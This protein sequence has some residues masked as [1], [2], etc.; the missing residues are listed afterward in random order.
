MPRAVTADQF[1]P[2]E[3]YRLAEH[4]PGAPGEG[5]VRVAIKAAGVSFVDVLTARGEYQ[6]KPPLPYV[7][8]SEYAGVV[9]AVGAGV[10]ALAVGDRV[11]GSSLGNTFAEAGLF[12][13]ANVSK[14][15]EGMDFAEAAVFPVNYQT[16]WHALVDRAAARPG[17]S[18]LV[19]G[20]AGGTGFA[21]VEVGKYLGLHVI[22]SASSPEKQAAARAGGADAVVQTGAEDWREQVKAANGGK[23]IDIVFDPVG[24]DATDLAFRTL[25][26]GGR[27]L[28]IGFT[29]GLTA[30]KTNLPLLKCASL[31]GVQMR[32]HALARP[33]EAAANRVKVMELAGE[34]HFH[35]A[36][37]ARFPLED[38]VAAMELAFSGKAAGRVVLEMA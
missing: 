13:A 35:P 8:G 19:L 2:P 25:G 5:Q 33:E 29:G 1:G 12:N 26:Y 14:V 36:I 34:G 24:G 31:V 38:Y 27:H 22:A 23:D 9:E 30:L 6:F 10:S 28:V 11:F 21:A 15:P 18:L 16:A 17:E 4:D 37:A 3:S 20:A 7:P 32:G